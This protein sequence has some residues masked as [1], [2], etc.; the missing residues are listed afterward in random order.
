MARSALRVCPVRARRLCRDTKEREAASDGLRAPP[1]P[2]HAAPRQP[3]LPPR[4]PRGGRQRAPP[5]VARRSHVGSGA[6]AHQS[7]SPP[8]HRCPAAALD[9]TGGLSREYNIITSYETVNF[10]THPIYYKRHQRVLH[11]TDLWFV[12]KFFRLHYKRQDTIDLIFNPLEFVRDTK[13]F[14][15]YHYVKALS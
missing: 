7:A 2:P 1:C 15:C 4:H 6:C 9:P 3:A 10:R 14:F 12:C 5:P 8:C 13:L 11:L